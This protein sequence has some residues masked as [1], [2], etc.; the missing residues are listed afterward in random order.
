MLV[1]SSGG[2]DRLGERPVDH[3][4]FLVAEHPLE[5]GIDCLRDH[6]ITGTLVATHRIRD[7]L[8]QRG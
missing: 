3:L 7:V 5:G 8:E 4:L 1:D 2:N 6:R